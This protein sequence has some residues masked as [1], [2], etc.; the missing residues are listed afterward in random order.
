MLRLPKPED[1]RRFREFL[2]SV[3][4]SSQGLEPVLLKNEA[5]SVR[6]S[7]LRRL[8]DS[9]SEP[10]ALHIL[11]RWFWVGAPAENNADREVIPDWVLSLCLE[12]GLLIEQGA[13]LTPVVMLMPFQGMWVASDP[14]LRISQSSDA[15]L[16]LSINPTTLLLNRFTIRRPA[17]ATLDLGT[18]CGAQA[19]SAAAHSRSVT[20][21]DLNGRAVEFARFNARLNGCEHMECLA[22]D[23][24]EPVGGRTFDLIVANPPFYVTPSRRLLYCENPCE[25]DQLCRRLVRE[26]PAHLE[27]G[28]YFQMLC[29][30]VEVR[31]QPWQDRLSEWLAGTGCDAW[32]LHAHA[33]HPA[34]YAQTRIREI[35]GSPE[36]D[37]ANYAEWMAYYRRNQVEAI[38]SGLLAMRRRSGDNWTRFQDMPNNP[39]GPFGDAILR[40]FAARD[41]LA[42]HASREAMLEMVP[43]IAPP[44]RLELVMNHAGAGWQPESA[45]LALEGHTFWQPLKPDVA[46]F[47][48]FFDGRRTLREVIREVAQ[49][50]DANPEQVERECLTV[51]RNMIELGYVVWANKKT[52]VRSQES[53]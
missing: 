51:V 29:D 52:E 53:E 19:L 47:L 18:G 30:W 28:G 31:G 35:T 14:A 34:V 45:R 38:H 16:V 3:N 43:K 42:A 17:R 15:E 13:T 48:G 26:A 44:A 22:G 5:V 1:A 20:A 25:L 37:D 27:E 12:W 9:T 23:S 39:A 32:V 10:S 4:Y 8:L 24:F 49:S 11:A 2:A 40:R 6:R 46:E 36:Q 7:N 33:W 41:F 50:A 21:T